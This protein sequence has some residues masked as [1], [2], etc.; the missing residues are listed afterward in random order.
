[1]R[2]ALIGRTALNESLYDGQTVK[3]RN[4]YNLLRE[5]AG[6]NN[7]CLVDT[8]NYKNH[9]LRTVFETVKAVRSSEI[10]FVCVSINGRKV[11][12]PFFYYLNKLIKKEMCHIAIGGRL[13]KNIMQYPRWKKYVRSFR[14]NWVESQELV[15][16]LNKIGITNVEYMPNFKT[17]KPLK[18]SD[19]VYADGPIYKYCIFSRIQE[20][21]GV[22]DA[23]R[24]IRAVNSKF[25]FNV[26]H[27]DLYGP[28]DD[29]YEKT[30][31]DLLDDNRDIAEY[32]GCVESEKSIEVVK[33]YFALLF[34]T[35]YF[36]EGIPGTII[37][38]LCAGVPVIARR[39]HFCDEM[40]ENNVNA[41]VYE[42]NEPEKLEEL[43][44]W[45]IEHKDLVN[46]MKLACIEKGSMYTKDVAK[47]YVERILSRK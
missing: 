16:S 28:I 11:F 35:R 26:A 14:V 10:T 33:N 37:D 18:E 43:I 9:V 27:L 1:M 32:K 44:E 23:I 42:F 41:L 24:A 25:G 22:E 17:I 5:V 21:K 4:V 38:S 46:S 36:N 40:L 15:D 6:L 39:W 29:D 3:T 19:L 45:S 13:E 12:F 34:P 2:V 47:K 8:Y 20:Q 31:Q 30:L 7:V